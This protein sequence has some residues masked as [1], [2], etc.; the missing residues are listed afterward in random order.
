L[1]KFLFKL[2]LPQEAARRKL[3]YSSWIFLRKPLDVSFLIQA[4]CSSVSR[5]SKFLFKLDLTQEA[6]RRKFFYSSWIFLSKPLDVSFFIFIW[7]DLPL[8]LQFGP[9]VNGKQGH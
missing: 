1:S 6:A 5:S 4:G 3:F 7:L 9:P 8:D 2:D